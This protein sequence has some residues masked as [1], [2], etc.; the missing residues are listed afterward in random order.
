[1]SRRRHRLPARVSVAATRARRRRPRTVRLPCGL[2]CLRVLTADS[3]RFAAHLPLLHRL[4]RRP[5]LPH[6]GCVPS[7]YPGPDM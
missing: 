7:L 6:L 5:S 2:A 1:M 3:G 4:P